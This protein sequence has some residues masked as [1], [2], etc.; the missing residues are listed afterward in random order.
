MRP[1]A[2]FFVLML[3]GVSSAFNPSDYYYADETDVSVSYTNFSLNGNAYSIVYFDGKETFLLRDGAIVNDSNE[4]SNAVFGYY[5]E[6]YYPSEEELAEIRSYI[7]Q[8]NASRNN[9]Y[10]VYKNKEEYICRTAIFTDKRIDVFIDGE[11]QKLWCHDD[12]SCE[13]NAMFL[14][15]YGNEYFGWGTYEILIQPLKDFSY[16]SYGIDDI[17]NNYTYKLDNLNENSL[18]DTIT[19]IKNKIPTLVEYSGDIES[20]IFRT[21]RFDDEQDRDDCYLKCYAMCPAFDLDTEVLDDLEDALDVLYDEVQPLVNYDDNTAEFAQET[22]DRLEYRYVS[23]TGAKYDEKFNEDEGIEL[24]EYGD[25]AAK[26]V[27][28]TTFMMKLE[29]MKSLRQS[30]RSKIDTGQFTGLDEE[31]TLYDAKMELVREGAD[32]IYQLYNETIDAKNL[33]NSLLF[34]ISTKEISPSNQETYNQIKAEVE[35][36]DLEFEDGV[37]PDKLAELRDRYKTAGNEAGRLL[38]AVSTSA[39]G[40]AVSTFRSLAT[41]MNEGLASLVQATEIAD[42]KSIPENKYLAFGT[43]TVLIFLSLASIAFLVFLYVVGGHRRSQL[44][45]VI[46]AGFVVLIIFLALFSGFLF[47]YMDKA[48]SEATMDEF[49]DDFKDRSS[50]ALVGKV[51]LATAEEEAAVKNCINALAATMAEQNKSVDIYYFKPGYVCKKNDAVFDGDCNANI[52]EH[53]SVI[54]LNPSLTTEAPV[55]SAT[56]IS[57]A[58]ITAT[59]E[60]YRSCPLTVMFE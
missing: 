23:V 14:F 57:R 36:A 45:Y 33:V 1:H 29:E 3:L 28:N 47:F 43:F 48:A 18:V 35:A 41:K 60:Y 17:L 31:I 25:G 5:I 49:L 20:T 11:K 12:A 10:G 58:E 40:T 51:D 6:E 59:K 32:E 50:I 30:I 8:F 39:S 13:M 34:E 7:D 22:K 21:P 9:G 54:M 26:I 16:A 42:A 37:T 56:F 38:Q 53:E 44:K 19:Y 55:L 52:D 24:E 2:I 4:I 15:Q 27:T 46:T